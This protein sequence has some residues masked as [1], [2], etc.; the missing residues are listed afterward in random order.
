[1]R[2]LFGAAAELEVFLVTCSAEDLIVLK[3]FANRPRDWA[4]AETIVARQQAHLDRDYVLEQLEP[5]STLKGI[6]EVVDRVRTLMVAHME[7]RPG[8]RDEQG[9]P[10][11]DGAN[12]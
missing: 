11:K 2:S 8:Q 1:M 7:Q 3:A 9:P 12:T 5:L 4:D 10:R 6:P